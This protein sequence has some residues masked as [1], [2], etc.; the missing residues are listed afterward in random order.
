M[1]RTLQLRFTKV[2]TDGGVYWDSNLVILNDTSGVHIDMPGVDNDVTIFRSLT[3]TNFV[4]CYHDYFGETLD[5][6]LLDKGIGQTVKFRLNKE[7]IFGM[8][9]GDIIDA[10]DVNPEDPTDINNAFAGIDG[11]Y[12]LTKDSEY[13]VCKN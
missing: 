3:G 10:G 12:F 13:F 1:A 9:I 2:I 5:H 4:T 7:P 6:I 8:V 11:Q